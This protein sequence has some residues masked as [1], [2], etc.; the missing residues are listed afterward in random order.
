MKPF[1]ST[2]VLVSCIT[3]A[4]CHGKQVDVAALQQQYQQAHKQYVDD[5]VSPMTSGASAALSGKTAK[6]PTPQQ[7]ALQ[8]QKCDQEAKK[9][10]ALQQQLQA[11]SQ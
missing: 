2:V 9:A 10:G 6:A 3:L 5:C 1:L 11:A 4:G 7:E 8:Q